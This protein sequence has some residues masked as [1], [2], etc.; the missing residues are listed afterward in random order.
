MG[1]FVDEDQPVRVIRI[2]HNKVIVEPAGIH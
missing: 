1:N 2:D